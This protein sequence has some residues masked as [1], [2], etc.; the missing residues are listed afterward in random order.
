MI[1]V[2]KPEKD[3]CDIAVGVKYLNLMDL[4]DTLELIGKGTCFK[5]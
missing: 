4:Y 5:F 3:G 1:Y 2:C